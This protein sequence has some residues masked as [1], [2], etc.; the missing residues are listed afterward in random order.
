M[1][2]LFLLLR[3]VTGMTAASA[4]AILLGIVFLR[5]AAAFVEE[6]VGVLGYVAALFTS[7]FTKGTPPK[8]PRGWV[9]S[10][11]QVGLAILFVSMIVSPFLPSA[12]VFLHMIGAMVVIA[13]FWYARMLLTGVRLEILCLP[14]FPVWLFYYA[15]C[16][17]WHD[18]QSIPIAP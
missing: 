14:L 8:D 15:M 2:A 10:T 13:L 16:I 11:P 7:G 9:F 17:F 18:K 3:I 1:K 12:K 6:G 4:I 5:S